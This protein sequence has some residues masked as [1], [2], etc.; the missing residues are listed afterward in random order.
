[1]GWGG[2]R[3]RL[4]RACTLR[5][6]Q[7]DRRFITQGVSV[8]D[9]RF[10]ALT[11]SLSAERSRRGVLGALAGAALASFGFGKAASAHACRS[12]GNSCAANGDCCSGN[13]VSEGRTRKICHCSSPGDCPA[14]DQCHAPTCVGGACGLQVRINADCNDGDA[15]T[16]GDVCQENGTCA[17]APVVCTAPNECYTPGTCQNGTCS[18]P[19][20]HGEQA[21][22]AGGAGVCHLTDCCIPNSNETTCAGKCGSQT[23]NCGQAV[24]CAPCC[25]PNGGVC[26][27]NGACCSGLCITETC[28]SPVG[29][30]CADDIECASQHCCGGVCRDLA[31]DYANCGACGHSCRFGEIC[32]AGG[33]LCGAGSACPADQACVSGAC[34]SDCTQ[35]DCSTLCGTNA[36]C[37]HGTDQSFCFTANSGVVCALYCLHDADCPGEGYTCG[38]SINGGSLADICQGGSDHGYCAFG[39]GICP[40]PPG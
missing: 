5:S 31:G 10:D 32:S 40:A 18:A 25:A 3:R 21:S 11:K 39:I 19:S 7:I 38:L 4:T 15:C 34:T 35:F 29:A 36:Q 23:N 27:S 2:F 17:G 37:L 13:C 14:G 9:S 1:V 6:Y 22:C 16:T 20:F 24:E 12:I 30:A 8:D 26:L 33:C 28:R